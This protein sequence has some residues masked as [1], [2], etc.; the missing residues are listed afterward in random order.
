MAAQ[1]PDLI[2]LGG[3][4]PLR[5]YLRSLWQ[6]RQF[7]VNVP[8]SELRAQ[9]MDT[10]LGNLWH[11]LNPMLSV[12]V[13]FFVFG[14]LLGTNRGIDNFIVYLAIGVFVYSYSNRSVIAGASTISANEGLIRSLAFPRAVLPISAVI[15]ETIAF[16]PA[17]AL[18]ILLALGT[19]EALTWNWL[20]LPVVMVLQ[21]VFNLGAAF[22]VARVANQFRDVRNV[23]PFI[24]R[25]IFYLSGILY[26]FAAF[27]PD[28]YRSMLGVAALNPFYAF[29]SL[30]RGAL[31]SSYPSQQLIEDGYDL[32]HPWLWPSVLVWTPVIIV[33]GFMYF[34]AA[35]KSY[36]RG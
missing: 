12:A 23:L 33:L 15:R 36:G 8:L 27:V 20:W 34:R 13:Y 7:A 19:G 14:V 6:R 24:F 4:L 31:M 1:H 16:L 11:L 22:V 30:Y 2:P 35:E 18:M 26:S 21:A 28:E 5:V 9:H 29:I 10:V 32:I 3:S 17:L 25:L